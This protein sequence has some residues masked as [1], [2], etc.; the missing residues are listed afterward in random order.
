M[1]SQ[2]PT[3]EQ[4]ARLDQEKAWHEWK[5]RFSYKYANRHLGPSHGYRFDRNTET[6]IR[7]AGG[8]WDGETWIGTNYTWTL[9]HMWTRIWRDYGLCV[10]FVQAETNIEFPIVAAVIRTTEAIA[11]S[12]Y[13]NQYYSHMCEKMV[14]A[15]QYKGPLKTT[16]LRA[17]I[18]QSPCRC[19]TPHWFRFER[20]MGFPLRR[21]ESAQTTMYGPCPQ[22]KAA[23]RTEHERIFNN[24]QSATNAFAV[25]ALYQEQ[26]PEA[27]NLRQLLSKSVPQLP[28]VARHV[29]RLQPLL[30]TTPL[31]IASK[32]G[33]T[34]KYRRA[35]GMQHQRLELTTW[36]PTP[37][38][39]WPGSLLAHLHP[40]LQKV[41]NL[42]KI[43]QR[44]HPK[45]PVNPTLERRYK[46]LIIFAKTF[47]L[48]RWDDT[49]LKHL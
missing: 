12:H 5:A 48:D 34:F 35:Y 3:V 27:H 6:I 20:H 2:Y 47:F 24:V 19:G 46:E 30:F 15:V 44:T 31:Q 1:E 17:W 49:F 22:L 10:N 4:W 38:W 21:T 33:N 40:A 45:P 43:E 9:L 7:M 16:N 37:E 29:L 36:P 13:H 32:L 18:F 42:A 39:I 26:T 11:F 23:Q 28:T 25:N 8:R 14:E 41:F